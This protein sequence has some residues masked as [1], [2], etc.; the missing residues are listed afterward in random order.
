M[1]KR[2]SFFLAACAFMAMLTTAIA[3]AQAPQKQVHVLFVGNSL[4][5]VN[6]LPALFGALANAQTDGNGYSTDLIAAPGGSI[7]ERWEDGLAA[8]EITS[9]H[10][11]VLV[12][13]ERGGTLAC[14]GKPGLR[15]QP[16]CANSL[17]AHR[18]F[19]K[20][21]R[22]H[23]MRVIVLGTW[24]PDALWQG[25]LSRGLRK[26]ADAIGAEV[27]DSGPPVRTFAASHPATP[28]YTDAILHP[29]IDASLLVAGLLYHQIAGTPAHATSIEMM[30]P[31][32][33]LRVDIRP[34]QL[35]SR[36][37]R[38]AGDGSRQSFA[39]ERL[40]PLLDARAL[41]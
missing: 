29:S 28:M 34:D 15:E 19:A 38:I 24:G 11:Q 36:Q 26:L 6:N 14:L 31:V 33:P 22:E 16:D 27:V 35:V 32:F 23:N 21:A 13:Q 40:R 1:N 3:S 30:A 17:G 2:R 25:Q 10:W 8:R 41:P 20:L 9:G 37:A 18:R 12:L 39:V 4:P 7:A 5:Y